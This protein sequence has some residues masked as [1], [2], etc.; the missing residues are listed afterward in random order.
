MLVKNS[1]INHIV[2]VLDA[3]ASMTAHVANL[4]TVWDRLITDLAAQVKIFP[5][6]ET[7]ISLYSFTT[8]RHNSTV[9]DIRNLVWDMDVLRMP[10]IAGEYKVIGGTPLCTAMCQVIGEIRE[11]PMRHG[12]HTVLLYLLT[13]GQELHSR[14]DDITRL[15]G[16]IKSLPDTWTVAG[17]VPDASGKLALQRFG[18]AP[19]N[20]SVWD[21]HR[22]DGALE[23]GEQIATATRTYM[24]SRST[25]VRSTKNLFTM[26]APDV[27]D[28]KAAL[29]PMTPGSFFFIDVTG[30]D[31]AKVDNGRID[32]FYELKTGKPYTPG[33]AY[34]EMTDRVRIQE[35]K[36]VAV[37][38]PD[39]AKKEADVY[40]GSNARKMLGLPD[41]EVRVSPAKWKG[42]KVFVTSHSNNR[43]LKPGT[44]LLVMR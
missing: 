7:R 15:P 23:A 37:A 20:V 16:V 18:F 41:K 8:D 43:K 42:Y 4:I 31:L 13:D 10:S 12:D 44:R 19:G 33:A 29:V 11:I 39:H 6:Q 17:L 38:I 28:I 25:G 21:P 24:T 5:D 3:S 30:E 32:Q 27:K 26:S 22:A 35:N 34:Y 1:Y 40:V 14:H 9:M 2:G 36:K